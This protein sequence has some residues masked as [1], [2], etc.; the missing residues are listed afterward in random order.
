MSWIPDQFATAGKILKLRRD[1]GAW[2][3]GWVVLEAGHNRLSAD[4]VPDF[5]K[6]SKAHLRATGDAQT[7]AKD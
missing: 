1:D 7:A 3:N 5:H 6:L 2:E 4:Q